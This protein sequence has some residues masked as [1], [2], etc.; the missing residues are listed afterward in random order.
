MKT[1]TTNIANDEVSKG[2]VTKTAVAHI[3]VYGLLFAGWLFLQLH[4]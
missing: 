3:F 2:Y 4:K 1:T